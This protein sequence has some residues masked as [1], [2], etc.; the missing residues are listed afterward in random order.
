[1]GSEILGNFDIKS[2]GMVL[3]SNCFNVF[4]VKI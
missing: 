4:K 2:V 3:M 1:M